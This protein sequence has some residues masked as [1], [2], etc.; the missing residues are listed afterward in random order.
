MFL[1][2]SVFV[3]AFRRV[4]VSLTFCVYKVLCVL[5]LIALFLVLYIV[6]N[7]CISCVCLRTYFLFVFLFFLVFLA[8]IL[9]I[10]LFCYFLTIC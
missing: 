1:L 2:L 6:S 9:Y 4:P 5:Y 8:V 3:Y 10:N 7:V